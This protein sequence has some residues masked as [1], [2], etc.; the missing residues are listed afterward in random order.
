MAHPT[1]EPVLIT[2]P[3]QKITCVEPTHQNPPHR[4]YFKHILGAQAP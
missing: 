2:R 4:G 3:P 1:A